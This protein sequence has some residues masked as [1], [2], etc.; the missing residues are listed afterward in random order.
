[1]KPDWHR[2]KAVVL[3][4]D[5]WGLCAWVPDAEAHARLARQP[6][7]A[8]EPGRRY[9]RSTLE[10]AADVQ[11]LAATL[12]E[13]RGADG[14]PPALQ[15]NT[16]LASPDWPH[17][18]PPFT[19]GSLALRS[20]GTYQGRWA[21]PGLLQAMLDAIAAGAWWPEL[22]GLHHIPED[23]WLA[24]LRRGDPDA[25]A[26]L[27]EESLLCAAVE[28]SGEY[29]PRESRTTRERNLR[30]ALARFVALFG[31]VPDSFCPPDYRADAWLE[32]EARTLGVAT[33]QGAH[34]R[35]PSL[36]GALRR[37][38]APAP[39]PFERHGLFVMPARTAFEPR[40]DG[41]GAGR[42]GVA[43][44]HAAAHRAWAAG[45]PLVLSTHRL[46]YAH[47]DSAWSAAGRAALRSLLGALAADGASF[48][49][50]AEVRELAA[51]GWSV[52][53]VG[54]RAALLRIAVPTADGAPIRV[55]APAYASRA[56]LLPI[57]GPP[58]DGRESIAVAGGAA[59]V[60]ASPGAWRI[61]WEG[62]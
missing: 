39:F 43:A 42:V 12:L 22:H 53:G 29:D 16:I 4:S 44:A 47:L 46:N 52:R 21:R 17:V 19:E 13:F 8:S 45:R 50:D 56:R 51:R 33:I 2:L 57:P 24:A 58:A 3:E 10:S 11:E 32:Q 5:D 38:F 40:G 23:A 35:D 7:F 1:M 41:S 62:A 26:A 25:R 27:A 60:H 48:W 34:E 54:P 31:R 14:V 36:L 59:E 15:A 20:L 6:A 49:V 30:I 55:P 18:T 61:E 9:G 37:R 28:A